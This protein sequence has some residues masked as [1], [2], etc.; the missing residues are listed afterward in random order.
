MKLKTTN[1]RSKR[2]IEKFEMIEKFRGFSKLKFSNCIGR[3][4]IIFNRKTVLVEVNN[5]LN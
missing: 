4:F 1:K 2:V 5:C 3:E